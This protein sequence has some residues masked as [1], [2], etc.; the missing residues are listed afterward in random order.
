MW[1]AY[2]KGPGIC[3][4]NSNPCTE[5]ENSVYD[6]TADLRQYQEWKVYPVIVRCRTGLS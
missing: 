1:N 5:V 6:Y 3:L 2:G 4:H